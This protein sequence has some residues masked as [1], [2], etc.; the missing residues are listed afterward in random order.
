MEDLVS[1]THRETNLK[2]KQCLPETAELTEDATKIG[3]F[4]GEIICEPPNNQLNKYD[5]TLFW[6]GEKLVF[7]SSCIF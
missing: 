4:D 5:G 6:R 2:C 3:Q 7:I 1:F